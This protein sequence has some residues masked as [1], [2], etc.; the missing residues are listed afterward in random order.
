MLFV[1]VAP[2]VRLITQIVLWTFPFTKH[3][4]GWLELVHEVGALQ[5]DREKREA[6]LAVRRVERFATLRALAMRCSVQVSCLWSCLDVSLFAGLLVITET[7]VLTQLMLKC[8]KG[9]GDDCFF[10]DVRA[11]HAFY[12][13]FFSVFFS[14]GVCIASPQAAAG[15]F[16][17]F[18]HR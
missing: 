6:Y 13:T 4:H 8:P 5:A 16:R 14:Y 17:N 1:L 18:F 3:Q 12:G 2:V 11:K 9:F 10:V 7:K 15:R